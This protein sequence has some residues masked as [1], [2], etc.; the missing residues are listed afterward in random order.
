M[1]STNKS[2][3][4]FL[5]DA[6]IA[7]GITRIVCS[8]GS[9]NA[10]IVIAA[11]VHPQMNTTVVHDERVA[12]FYALG[13]S[14]GSNEPV[15]VVC[16][17]GSAVVNYFPAVTEAFYQSVPLVVISA[18]RPS[19]WVNHGDGQTIMQKGVFGNHVLASS[20][21]NESG[22]QEEIYRLVEETMLK[23]NGFQK[24]PVH[25][26]CPL[27]EPLYD[28]EEYES[29]FIEKRNSFTQDNFEVD[30]KSLS[31][32][33]NKVKKVM[34]LCGQHSKSQ[35]LNELLNIIADD[36]SVAVLVENTSN[37]SS[38]SFV[39]CIDRTL[40][41]IENDTDYQPD[42]L[43]SIGGAIISKK[44]KKFLRASK[45]AKHW[46]VGYEFPDMDTYRLERTSYQTSPE[47]FFKGLLEQD[48]KSHKSSFGYNWR[49][50]NMQI[51]TYLEQEH[52]VQ[53]SPYSDLSVIDVV[54]D[55][56][57]EGSNIHMANSSLV[58]YCQLFDPIRS[59]TYFSNRGTSGIDGST[60]TACG[61]A[62]SQTN[63]LNVL[64]TGDVSFFYDSNALWRAERIK[65]LRIILVNNG[66]GGIFRI[67][68]GPSG[69]TQLENYFEA[70][71]SANAK[72]ICEAYN[73]GYMAATG[74]AEIENSMAE[75][76]QESD[77]VKL[78]EIFTPRMDNAEV[79]NTFFNNI[80]NKFKTI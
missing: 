67:I 80:T 63:K 43:I 44:I 65:N 13:M 9:R 70:H 60:S 11:D 10:P 20:E 30:Y 46:K 16:T 40:A 55:C 5:I 71:H 69:A 41:G 2:G 31:E 76:F 33:W 78:L 1:K 48:L 6:L 54:L 50:L 15:A 26:N 24:G 8:P 77:D 19:E 53:N 36:S 25:F 73:V 18:D 45:G 3:I 66:G 42:L 59:M 12:G 68:P 23:S 7:N 52:V 32:E 58:R 64:L 51:Q 39:H 74:I 62:L 79:L 21:V 27:T 47:K 37:I 17:S 56:I 14:L 57:P 29:N 61:I 22:S 34:I 72:G 38:K 49:K 75:F 4:K 28:L 35:Y